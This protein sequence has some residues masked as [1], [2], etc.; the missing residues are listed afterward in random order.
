LQIPG[1]AVETIADDPA[2]AAQRI[3]MVCLLFSPMG[4]GDFPIL[5]WDAFLSTISLSSYWQ[6]LL[7]W[8][9][10]R[11]YAAHR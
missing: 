6:V 7:R 1:S 10:T 11:G 8:R 3:K 5:D 4:K 9:L 2:R